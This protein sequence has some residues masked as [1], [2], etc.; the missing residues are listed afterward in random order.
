VLFD[1]AGAEPHF[2]EGV[3][4][5]PGKTIEDARRFLRTEKG[6]APFQEQGS[7]TT[8]VLD[9]GRKQVLE[10]E[11]RQGNYALLCFVPD[12]KG[13]PPHAQKGMVSPG[14]VD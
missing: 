14:T 7:F 8:A 12:R 5:K 4:L 10:V 11:A 1:N 13:G 2:I 6:E 9:G 3:L